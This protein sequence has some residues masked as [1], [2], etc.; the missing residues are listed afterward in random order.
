MGLMLISNQVAL[1][2]QSTVLNCSSV[3]SGHAGLGGWVDGVCG[4]CLELDLRAT[5]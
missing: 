5:S 1:G 4:L 2:L 3:G